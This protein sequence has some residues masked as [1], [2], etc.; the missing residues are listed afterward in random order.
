MSFLENHLIW[1]IYYQLFYVYV[2]EPCFAM[3]RLDYIAK[4]GIR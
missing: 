1:S 3:H 2:V 4:Y